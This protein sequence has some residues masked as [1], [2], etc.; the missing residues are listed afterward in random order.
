VTGN[1][2]RRPGSQAMDRLWAGWRSSYVAVAGNGEPAGGSLFTRI[3]ASGLPDDETHVVWRGERNF[4]ILNAFPYT[5]G[6][7]LVMPYREV[8]EL[9]DLTPDE[10]AELWAAVRDAVVAIKAAYAPHGVNVGLNLGEAA[11]AGIP[12]H[13]HIHVLPRWNA[14]S[15]FMTAV[16]EVRVLPE[17]LGD[18]WRKLRAAWPAPGGE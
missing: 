1:G 11:G 5:C 2:G 4:A 10:S 12:S 16:A 3:L 8:G 14:D 9:E 13:M 15:N 6:H 18:T 17:A 7:V